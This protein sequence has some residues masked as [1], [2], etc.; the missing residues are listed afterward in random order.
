MARSSER[1]CFPFDVLF[2]TSDIPGVVGVAI[3]HAFPC[4]AWQSVCFSRGIVAGPLRDSALGCGVYVQFGL[5]RY[6]SW[7]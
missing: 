2:L 7:R 3:I 4:V 6:W 5:C 1:Q